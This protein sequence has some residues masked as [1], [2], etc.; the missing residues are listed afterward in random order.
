MN[1]TGYTDF[2]KKINGFKKY[3]Y[4]YIYLKKITINWEGVFSFFFFFEEVF[5]SFYLWINSKVKER[6]GTKVD[7]INRN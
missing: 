5:L 4:I 3:I 1:L 6:K 7:Q 2:K